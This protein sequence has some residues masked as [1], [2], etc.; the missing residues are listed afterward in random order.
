MGILFTEDESDFPHYTLVLT[1]ESG[2][3][4]AKHLIFDNCFMIEIS[5]DANYS[6]LLCYHLLGLAPNSRLNVSRRGL[7]HSILI[8]RLEVNKQKKIPQELAK[9]HNDSS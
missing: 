8:S 2:W 3:Q 9:S 1:V 4:V 5:S 6:V 7:V